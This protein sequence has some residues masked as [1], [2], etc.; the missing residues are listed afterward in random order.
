MVNYARAIGGNTDF[1]SAQAFVFPKI[2]P[3]DEEDQLY[4][5]IL[6][7]GAGDD[8]FTKIRQAG[9]FIE[10]Q[11]YSSD[12]SVPN[13]LIEL[14]PLLKEQ[15]KGVQNLQM[16]LMAWKNNLLYLLSSGTHQAFLKRKEKKL[17]LTE[18]SPFEEIVSG[19]LKPGDK[20]LLISGRSDIQKI[21]WGSDTVEHFLASSID[22]IEEE[23]SSLVQQLSQPEPVSIVL[24]E[25]KSQTDE[26][27]KS[28]LTNL[29]SRPQP[30]RHRFK[31][32]RLNPVIALKFLKLLPKLLPRTRRAIVVTLVTLIVI[33]GTAFTFYRMHQHNLAIQAEIK[34][35]LAIAE[36]QYQNAQNVKDSDP[37]QAQQS[38]NDAHTTVTS[39]LSRDPKNKDALALSQQIDSNQDQILKIYQITDW[40]L[41]LS[42]DLV[43]SG[44]TA[45]SMT[46]S[47]SN[48][49]LLDPD[50]K[51]LVEIDLKKKNNT[52]LAGSNQLGQAEF[53]SLNGDTAFSYSPDKG[54]VAV[55]T[56]DQK[57]TVVAKPDS[58]WGKI[59]SIVGF[60][61]NVYALDSGKNQIWK[62][63]PT[64][65]SYSDKETYLASGVVANFTGA[66]QM[67]IDYS[68]WVLK[69]GPDILR[70]TGGSQD[71]FAVGGLDKNLQ[72]LK[73]LFVDED[74][75]DVFLLDSENSR[76]VV[77]DKN[78]QYK[79]QYVGDKFKT[80]DDLVVDPDQKKMF[81]LEGNKL[82]SLDLK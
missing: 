13:R 61:G 10:E 43:K 28:E 5:A 74:S 29:E 25:H 77:V 66:K 71:S 75:D 44:F 59:D 65:S 32:P 14:I 76:V 70:F 52:I 9:P 69:L 80:A 12:K 27:I 16:I 42:L 56:D 50:H 22:D 54:I 17:D 39:V 45:K 53:A 6:I 15:L 48:A 67:K 3:Q 37:N 4:L 35:D 19:H 40:P 24:I 49:L 31:I 72:E 33:T 64:K 8:V 57:V 20:L 36:A 21:N 38:L 82:Y 79:S 7:S 60:A 34:S 41:F 2:I 23:I 11:F 62:Y 58:E 78:G 55:N 47:L 26:Q 30:E 68:V 73:T 1:L 51:T 18:H 46:Y 81:L 63:V